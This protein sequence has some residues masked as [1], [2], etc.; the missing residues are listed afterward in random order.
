MIFCDTI[1][2]VKTNEFDLIVHLNSD[3]FPE[4]ASFILKAKFVELD[5]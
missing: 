1:C 5:Y 4:K 3:F 2:L